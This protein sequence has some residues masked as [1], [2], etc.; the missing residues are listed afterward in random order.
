MCTTDV[1]P[2]ISAVNHYALSLSIHGEFYLLYN[3]CC[4][5]GLEKGESFPGFI[6]LAL[7]TDFP[8]CD[9]LWK[10]Q[11]CCPQNPFNRSLL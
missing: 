3:A 6:G 9:N 1:G 10:K 8:S 4:I 11:A 2:A 7:T 5:N